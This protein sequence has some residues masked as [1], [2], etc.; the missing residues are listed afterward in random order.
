MQHPTRRFRQ[1]LAVAAATVTLVMLAGCTPAGDDA[2]GAAPTPEPTPIVVPET[3]DEISATFPIVAEWQKS[4]ASG[5]SCTEAE[6]E[7]ALCATEGALAVRVSSGSRLRGDA[8]DRVAETTSLRLTEWTS[9]EKSSATLAASRE[10]LS[11]YNGDFD[12]PADPDAG[13]MAPVLGTGTLVDIDFADWSGFRLDYALTASDDQTEER[14]SSAIVVILG[15]G[16]LV[17]RMQFNNPT[18]DAD[19]A[20]AEVDYWL[21][22]TLAGE[23]FEPT[24]PAAPSLSAVIE[25]APTTAE[26]A[27]SG[28][29]DVVARYIA[30]QNDY[31]ASGI[32]DFDSISTVAAYTVLSALAAEGTT[33]ATEG[34]SVTGEARFEEISASSH[35]LI[36]TQGQLENGGVSYEGCFITTDR[37]I[38]L[39]D[40]SAVEAT[41]PDRAATTINVG[42]D[43]LQQGW[44]VSS[45]YPSGETC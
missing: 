18:A 44:R 9:D 25:P 8:V 22:R 42:Y 37:T 15:N 39:P 43:R 17:Y 11:T 24:E 14:Q 10:E 41:T 13:F 1:A 5:D 36:D 2:G 30:L 19:V 12:I 35:K 45:T 34:Y 40:G 26:E 3:V 23:P 7:D 38:T 29:R 33:S 4:Y 31:V 27:V 21:D 20:D 28:G 32:V 16:P 6:P